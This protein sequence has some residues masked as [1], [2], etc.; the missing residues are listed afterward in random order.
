[1]PAQLTTRARVIGPL[2]AL[3]LVTILHGCMRWTAVP[4]P[5]TLPYKHAKAFRVTLSNGGIIDVKEPF[6]VRDTLVWLNPQRTAV[7]LAQVS[8]VEAH[9]EDQVATTLLVLAVGVPVTY[10]LIAAI[11]RD[12]ECFTPLAPANCY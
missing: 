5:R 10:L 7:P 8:L 11:I 1:M 12:S 9:T 3:M 2:A 6:I 4:E